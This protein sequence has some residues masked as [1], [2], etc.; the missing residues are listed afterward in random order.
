MVVLMKPYNSM[1]ALMP[2]FAFAQEL[3]CIVFFEVSQRR[4]CSMPV[5]INASSEVFRNA[6]YAVEAV[7]RETDDG[8]WLAMTT[9]ESNQNGGYPEFWDVW[10]LP[11]AVAIDVLPFRSIPLGLAAYRIGKFA[12][13][14][15]EI[16][17]RTRY[18][19]MQ[20]YCQTEYVGQ[21]YRHWCCFSV[22]YCT[23]NQQW[24]ALDIYWQPPRML[25]GPW[26]M[27]YVMLD[28]NEPREY[29]RGRIMYFNGKRKFDNEVMR[30][31]Q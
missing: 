11:Q 3:A 23:L 1:H 16:C 24:H 4:F 21:W 30:E 20:M 7:Y 2:L 13:H 26:W 28:M 8:V 29:G 25:Y 9:R 19:N 18:H 10:R 22:E 31:L 12:D 15:P 27:W 6:A 17:D 5:R 14:W